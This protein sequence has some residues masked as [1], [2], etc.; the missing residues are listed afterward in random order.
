MSLYMHVEVI[1]P[2]HQI[3]IGFLWP[4]FFYNS[5]ENI[6]K[7]AGKRDEL[8]VGRMQNFVFVRKCA[9]KVS[10]N[11]KLTMDVTVGVI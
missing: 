9:N 5:E 1:I 7:R 11:G 3:Y 10:G 4:V 2:V 8:L 6:A